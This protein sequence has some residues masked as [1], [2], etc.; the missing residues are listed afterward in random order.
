[1]KSLNY[2]YINI[3]PSMAQFNRSILLD[4]RIPLYFYV[5]FK[6]YIQNMCWDTFTLMTP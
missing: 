4:F 2:D 6:T 1:M 3:I 5:R